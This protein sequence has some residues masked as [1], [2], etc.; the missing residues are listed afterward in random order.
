MKSMR[1]SGLT[2]GD[3]PLPQSGALEKVNAPHAREHAAHISASNKLE[4][5]ST[6]K[7]NAGSLG[8]RNKG[9]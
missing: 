9:K 1:G 3:A 6:P 2:E 4:T 7:P 8:A 5:Y